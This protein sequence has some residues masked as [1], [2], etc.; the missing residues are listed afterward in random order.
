MR[1]TKQPL[2]TVHHLLQR[3]VILR[4][5]LDIRLRGVGGGGE[6]GNG[7]V[8]STVKRGIPPILGIL[9]QSFA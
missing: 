5:N 4:D 9:I 3:S 7:G 1:G 8:V 6:Q 2:R